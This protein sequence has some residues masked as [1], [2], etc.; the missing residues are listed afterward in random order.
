[1]M[2]DRFGR[3]LQRIP[4]WLQ[5]LGAVLAFAAVATWLTVTT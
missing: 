2:Q 5:A 1:M 4:P 3:A